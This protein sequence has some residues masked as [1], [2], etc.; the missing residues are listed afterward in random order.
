MEYNPLEDEHASGDQLLELYDV[1]RDWLRRFGMVGLQGSEIYGFEPED[2]I[3][4]ANS[5]PIFYA[6]L[7]AAR[8]R[9]LAPGAMALLGVSG[10][11]A[12][13]GVVYHEQYMFCNPAEPDDDP[14]YITPD[15]QFFAPQPRTSGLHLRS[16]TIDKTDEGMGS[17]AIDETLMDGDRNREDLRKQ[18]TQ[19]LTAIMKG[20]WTVAVR[21]AAR[22]KARW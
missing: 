10:V 20:W 21:N 14:R 8:S 16:Y 9:H 17:W 11:R 1:T 4:K 5:P 22:P 2:R 13:V 19:A 7:S 15:V 12:R 3:V 6:E 18:E